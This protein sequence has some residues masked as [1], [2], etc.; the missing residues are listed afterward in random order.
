MGRRIGGTK[1]ESRLAVVEDLKK[2]KDRGSGIVLN[3][4][5]RLMHFVT[6][7]AP[8][9]EMCWPFG[10]TSIRVGFEKTAEFITRMVLD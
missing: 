5:C 4:E 3:L 7:S 8:H 6:I 9:E 2:R 10:L 1:L